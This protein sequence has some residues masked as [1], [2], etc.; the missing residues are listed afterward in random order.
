MRPLSTQEWLAPVPR[1]AAYD[2]AYP[3]RYEIEAA[4]VSAALESTLSM[5]HVG[6]TSVPGLSGKPTID[7]AAGVPTLDL[8]PAAHARM[9]RLGYSYSGDHGLPQHVFNYGSGLPWRFIVHVVEFDGELWHDLV[10]FRDYLR[11]HP[12][13]AARYAALKET[14]LRER[15]D[16]YRGVHKSSFIEPI[17]QATKAARRTAPRSG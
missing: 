5:E 8:G 13:D 12:D 11:A 15:G 10:A 3:R 4:R 9:G 16:W 7:I 2:P 14:L 1:L 6:S 17:L